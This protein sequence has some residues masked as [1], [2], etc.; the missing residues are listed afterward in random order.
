MSHE[1]IV[2]VAVSLHATPNER[3]AVVQ[4]WP[5]VSFHLP[6]FTYHFKDSDSN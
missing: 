5:K 3:W 1:D 6:L 2:C 4:H